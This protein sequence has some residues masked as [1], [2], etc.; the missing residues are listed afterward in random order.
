V[1]ERWYFVS[2]GMLWKHVENDGPAYLRKPLIMDI[3]L[4]SVEEAK[5]KYPVELAQALRKQK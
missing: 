3:V 1:I 4:C 2:D 5:N